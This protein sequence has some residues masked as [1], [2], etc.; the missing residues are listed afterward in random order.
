VRVR[1]TVT[2]QKTVRPV[3]FEIT[4]PTREAVAAWLAVLGRRTGTS[5]PLRHVVPTASASR[6]L[7]GPWSNEWSGGQWAGFG[8]CIDPKRT[9]AGPRMPRLWRAANDRFWRER[10]STQY[11]AT[12]VGAG[13]VINMTGG[14]QMVFVNIQLSTLP[15]ER[16][17][18]RGRRAELRVFQASP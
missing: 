13:T 4:E 16:L 18:S 15:G 9:S 2:Q 7:C 17:R 14:G 8:H 6:S 10:D 5:S 3:P 1:S 11:S 12:L